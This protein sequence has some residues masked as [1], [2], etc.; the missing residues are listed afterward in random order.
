MKRHLFGWNLILYLLFLTS[1]QAHSGIRDALT[2]TIY[3]VPMPWPAANRF[4]RFFVCDDS[5]AWLVNFDFETYQ[6]NGADWQP[7]PSFPNQKIFSIYAPAHDNIWIAY[8]QKTDYRHYFKHFDGKKW[9]VYKSPGVVRVMAMD[10]LAPD[11]G[12]AVCEWGEIL[13]F[14]GRDWRRIYS[15]TLY[16]LSH[17]L[18]LPDGNGWIAGQSRGKG[19]V[20]RYD[21]KQWKIYNEIP[22]GEVC[23]I[24]AQNDSCCWIE[25]GTENGF[26][27]YSVTSSGLKKVDFPIKPE[28]DLSLWFEFY[29]FRNYNAC[30]FRNSE[31]FFVLIDDKWH[32]LPWKILNSAKKFQNCTM[33]MFPYLKDNLGNLYIARRYEQIPMEIRTDN[34]YFERI[35]TQG[36]HEYGVAMG[37]VDNN[38]ILDIYIV[39]HLGL[40]RLIANL[41]ALENPYIAGS[42]AA[43]ANQL[44][45]AGKNRVVKKGYSDVYDSGISMA[46]IENDGDLDLYLCSYYSNNI[47]YKNNGKARFTSF[48]EK[49]GVGGEEMAFS[50]LGVWGDVN[51]DGYIDLFVANTLK[52]NKLYL[53]DGTGRFQDVTIDAGLETKEGCR[54]PAFCDFDRDGDLDLFIGHS[55]GRIRLMKNERMSDENP[56]IPVFRE[57]TIECGLDTGSL[58]ACRCGIWGDVNNDGDMDLFLARA[59]IPDQL[60]LNDGQGHFRDVSEWA[61]FTDS[62]NTRGVAFFDVEND[63]DLDLFVGQDGPNIFYV[64]HGDGSFEIQTEKFGFTGEGRTTSVVTGDMY[65]PAYTRAWKSDGMLDL[66]VARQEGKSVVFL[67][68]NQNNRFLQF[69]LVG[70]QSNR[71]AIG[72]KVLFYQAGHLGEKLFLKGMRE[73]QAGGGFCSM[74]STIVHFGTGNDHE[75]DVLIN[76]PGG[77]QVVLRNLKPGQFLTVFE[78]DGFAR[79]FSRTCRWLNRNFRE[80]E[81]HHQFGMFVLLL[82]IIVIAWR[83]CA[84]KTW[85]NRISRIALFVIPL[86]LYFILKLTLDYSNHWIY[87]YLTFGLTVFFIAAVF[88]ANYIYSR[89]IDLEER[90]MKLLSA[91]RAFEHSQWLASYINKLKLIF[92]NLIPNQKQEPEIIQL[93][94]DAILN[95]YQY[96]FPEIQKIYS[97]A[98]Q[99]FANSSESARLNKSVLKLSQ[100]LDQVKI[101]LNLKKSL[102]DKILLMKT[103]EEISAVQS[104]I[105]AITQ[106]ID[107]YFSTPLQSVLNKILR[108]FQNE[109]V[110]LEF[111]DRILDD[112]IR[113][114]IQKA[115]LVFILENLL[116]NAFRALNESA[117][118]QITLTLQQ[119]EQRIFLYLR[120]NGAGIPPEIQANLFEH[121]VSSKENEKGGFGLYHSKMIVNK[122]GGSLQLVFS[123]PDEGSEFLLILKRIG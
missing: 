44:G 100:M 5:L 94:Y 22:F 62:T 63:G 51:N 39:D 80:P 66:Y 34:L 95:F 77:K 79:Y 17:I 21:R 98:L 26:A 1:N 102:N 86:S 65:R 106:K 31:H 70:T 59:P 30:H 50:E 41:P 97:L 67:N 56:E 111:L 40:N 47:L 9:Q 121:G 64:N 74:S 42:A 3:W 46:D 103:R 69:K 45:V 105:K 16:H 24:S 113:V 27:L 57:V 38:N 96:L 28:S 13:H 78:E 68:R 119:K 25:V 123:A 82:V 117:N 8:Y 84:R 114:R 23:S 109:K 88:G 32:S 52:S 91:C 99:V 4:E 83:I 37:D 118:P 61:G 20:L 14:D 116:S 18:M 29:N 36:A 87:D 10:F 112:E 35:E 71:D 76:F 60:F 19:I 54:N 49:A 53:N 81:N 108:E 11:D 72:S 92:A 55:T 12:W 6:W 15:P 58:A 104:N 115:E 85:G 7:Q 110:S 2:D 73:V 101:E 93:V 120:D 107:F 122:Y 48:T 75:L 89:Q 90:R 43:A 33:L